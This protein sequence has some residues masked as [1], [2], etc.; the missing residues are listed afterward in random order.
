MKEIGNR[1]LATWLIAALL[2]VGCQ[3]AP[4]SPVGGPSPQTTDAAIAEPTAKLVKDI[5]YV[6]E[7]VLLK[8]NNLVLAGTLTLP[9]AP[10]PHPGML[11]LTGSGPQNRDNGA[12]ELPDYHPYQT[13]VKVLAEN[14]IATLRC[15][16]RGVGGSTGDMDT[17]M[18][19]DL[20]ADGEA[21]LDYLRTRPELDPAQLGVLGHSQGGVIGVMLAAQRTDITFVVT[22]ASPVLNGYATVKDSLNHLAETMGVP[23]EIARAVAEQE[24][25]AMDLALAEEWDTLDAHLRQ[26]IFASFQELPQAQ[27]DTISDLDALIDGQVTLALANYQSD[28]FRDEMLLDPAIAW[29]QVDVPVL[30]LYAEHETTIFAETH[31]PVLSKLLAGNP[32]LTIETVM[33]VNHLF[34][35]AETGNPQMWTTLPQEIPE[36]VFTRI[37]NWLNAHVNSS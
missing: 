36:R 6:E 8:T 32:D 23:E 3:I 7:E 29:E 16:D 34:L 35:E 24:L 33:G 14:G 11:L 30:A 4:L 28:Q 5:G 21:A 17:V 27:R 12:P 18:V 15:D 2:L 37:A 13:L 9:A 1:S 19:A 25:T 20:I 26:V 22:M 10:G 31:A